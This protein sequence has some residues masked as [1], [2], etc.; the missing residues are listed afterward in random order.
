MEH[1]IMHDGY[2]S[3][4]V[5]YAYRYCYAELGRME[6]ETQAIAPT[7]S[8]SRVCELLVLLPRSAVTLRG[9]VTRDGK[10]DLIL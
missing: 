6:V 4:R 8:G 2:R 10:R 9:R 5:A 1:D 7:A 3:D